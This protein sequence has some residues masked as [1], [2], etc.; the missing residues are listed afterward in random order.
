MRMD[1]TEDTLWQ[2]QIEFNRIQVKFNM[3][4][5]VYAFLMSVLFVMH[6][7]GVI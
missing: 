6:L 2:K 7:F 4:M 1:K 5:T 3:A